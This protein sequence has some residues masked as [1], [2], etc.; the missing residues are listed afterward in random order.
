[1]IKSSTTERAAASNRAHRPSKGNP[2]LSK[3]GD[4]VACPVL[5]ED[6]AIQL[7]LFTMETVFRA[8]LTTDPGRSSYITEPLNRGPPA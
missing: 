8:N 6:Q 7:R 3:G 2:L 4:G 5:S 1:M